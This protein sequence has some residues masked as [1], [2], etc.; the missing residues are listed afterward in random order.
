MCAAVKRL[1]AAG[2]GDGEDGGGE[3]E[4]GYSGVEELLL[5]RK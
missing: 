4:E 1:L 3:A 5:R 2:G